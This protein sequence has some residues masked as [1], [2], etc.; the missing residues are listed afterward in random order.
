MEL[1]IEEVVELVDAA[2]KDS[3]YIKFFYLGCGYDDTNVI[4]IYARKGYSHGVSSEW[5]GYKIRLRLVNENF[6]NEQRIQ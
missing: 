6:I 4:N 5:K 1:T 3:N 2:C